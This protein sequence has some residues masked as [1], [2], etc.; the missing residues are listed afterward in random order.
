MRQLTKGADFYLQH[1]TET[2]K[3]LITA[4]RLEVDQKVADV[5]ESVESFFE[6]ELSSNTWGLHQAA[7]DHLDRFRSFLHSYYIEQHGFWPPDRF[8]DDTVQRLICNSMYSDFKVLYHH[9][10]DPKSNGHEV[11]S[12]INDS[13][14]V[15]VLQNIRS[16]DTR[17]KY[18]P[19][20]HAMP[21]LPHEDTVEVIPTRKERRNS[22]NPMVKRKLDKEQR[23]AKRAQALVNST[24]RDWNL[25]SSLLVRRFCKFE[26]R[27]ASDDMDTVSLADGRKVRWL[28]VYA[29]LQTLIST[30]QAPK[31]VRNTEGLTYPLCCRVPDLLPWQHKSPTSSIVTKSTVIQPDISYSHTNTEPVRPTLSRKNSDLKEKVQN[32]EFSPVRRTLTRTSS[33]LR[34]ASLRRL[35]SF[36]SESRAEDQNKKQSSFCEIYVPGYGNGLNEVDVEMTT[37]PI[38]DTLPRLPGSNSVSRESSNASSNSTWSKTSTESGT[39]IETPETSTSDIAQAMSNLGLALD[40]SGDEVPAA[41]QIVAPEEGLE[42]VHFNARTWDAVLRT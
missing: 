12:S 6:S 32:A 31:Q 27:A 2:S 3:D 20:P 36:S 5:A 37:S 14:G 42:T 34:T 8:Q 22:W 25:T 13:G 9:L 10:A 28:A 11:V 33:S 38:D 4:T 17:A 15:C 16:F 35:V 24:N 39:M 40:K 26:S 19:L 29:I 30:M 21:Q 23:N 7:R 1:L 41:I 18:S